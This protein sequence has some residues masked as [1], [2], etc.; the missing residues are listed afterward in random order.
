MMTYFLVL[1]H[2]YINFTSL[3]T[4]QPGDYFR[5]FACLII[6]AWFVLS[7]RC[8]PPTE[9]TQSELESDEYGMRSLSLSH[10]FSL[11]LSLSPS[12]SPQAKGREKWRVAKFAEEHGLGAP[13]AGN[14]YQAQWD[15]YVPQ[16]YKQFTD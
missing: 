3:F 11:P 15:D 2:T 6:F 5:W 14:L 1:P 9:M 12:P 7:I 10:P 16:L 8:S 13:V 4:V